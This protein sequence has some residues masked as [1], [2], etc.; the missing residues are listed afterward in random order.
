[1]AG[2]AA[3][4]GARYRSDYIG[5]IQGFGAGREFKR[6]DDETVIDAQISY[7]LGNASIF[8]QATNI[9]DEPFVTYNNDDR[10]EVIDHQ[11]YGATYLLGFGYKF[12]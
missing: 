7:E 11:T 8:L 3:R 10:R 9:N 2:F 6:V 12:F 1:M 4:V 5:E